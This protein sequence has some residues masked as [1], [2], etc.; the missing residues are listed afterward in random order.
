[1]KIKVKGKL[2]SHVKDLGVK[3]GQTYDAFSAVGTRLDAVSFT[4]EKDGELIICTL[5]PLNYEKIG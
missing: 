1:M 3:P 5:L 4:L 2:P